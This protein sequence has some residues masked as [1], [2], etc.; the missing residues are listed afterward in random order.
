MI[1]PVPM[2]E[3]AR[4][5]RP[6]EAGFRAPRP[7]EAG[8]RPPLGAA[9]DGGT[10]RLSRSAPEEI[11]EETARSRIISPSLLL[12]AEVVL[13]ELKPSVWF[14]I[15]RSLPVVAVGAILVALGLCVDRWP[16]LRQ[17]AIVIGMW[18]IGLRLALALL[19]WLGRTYV[20]TD[21]RALVQS[22]VFDVRVEALGL[23]RV[24]NTFVA[25]AVLQRLLGI[26]TIFF[27]T[28]DGDRGSLAWEHV[29]R[30]KKIHAHVV[31]QIDR[32]KRTFERGGQG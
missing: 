30:P 3:A 12:P 27:R 23:E 16:A 20:L 7:S 10:C 24:E 2:D 18:V 13:F 32:W 29:R 9:P 6:S 28:G 25:Q 11:T 8:L 19:Q 21:R 22:G 4:A 1:L 26:G 17:P 5:S 31:A 14:A 15:F